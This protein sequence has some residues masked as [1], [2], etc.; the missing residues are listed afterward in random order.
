[1]ITVTDTKRDQ[2]SFLGMTW[3]DMALLSCI[4]GRTSREAEQRHNVIIKEFADNIL[5]AI[6][7][8]LEQSV[9]DWA[10]RG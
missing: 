8:A 5:D 9:N 1:M 4:M 7:M 3:K 6:D 10:E 2:I